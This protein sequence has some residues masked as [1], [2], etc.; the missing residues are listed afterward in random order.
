MIFTHLNCFPTQDA[1]KIF[2]VFCFCL[3]LSEIEKFQSHCD[4]WHISIQQHKS[5]INHNQHSWKFNR[6][7][8]SE[9]NLHEFLIFL[10]NDFMNN[11]Y[12]A[13]YFSATSSHFVRN[14]KLSFLFERE[15]EQL[16]NGFLIDFTFQVTKL[17]PK[18][19]HIRK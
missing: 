10:I 4:I 15:L 16:F 12:V 9:L 3:P 6:W 18:L 8:L 19:S 14:K 5:S 2:K 1:L 11:F 7:R 17:A 13:F